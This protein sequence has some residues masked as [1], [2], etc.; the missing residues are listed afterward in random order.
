MAVAEVR[1]HRGGAWTS[2]PGAVALVL[3]VVQFFWRGHYVWGGFYYQDDFLLLRHGAESSFTLSYLMQE[4]AG[5]VW[6]GNFAMAWW[7]ARLAPTDWTLAATSILVIQAVAGAVM[8]LV[9]CRISTDWRV[10]IPLFVGYLACPLTLWAT[11]WWAAAINFVPLSLFMLLAV[12]ALLRRVQDEW[13]PGTVVVVLATFAGL[14][15]ME[16]A[17]LYPLL[18][19]GVAVLLA[20]GSFF[21]RVRGALRDLRGL[22]I[23]LVVVVGGWMAIHSSI[24][25]GAPAQSQAR[26]VAT[27]ARDYVFRSLLPGLAGGPWGGADKW[28]GGLH[29]TTAAAWV[30]SVVV[31]LILAVLVWRTGRTGRLALAL[32]LL[33]VVADFAVTA[34]G[35]AF[36]LGIPWGLFPRYVAD[37]VP[38]TVVA[39][40]FAC[41]D[42]VSRSKVGTRVLRSSR[43]TLSP[44]LVSVTVVAATVFYAA[45]SAWSTAV[46]GPLE[47]A[48]ESRDY[49]TTLRASIRANPTAVI[50]D[51]A[52]PDE[53]MTALFAEDARVSTVLATAPER[54]VFEVV[55]EELLIPGPTGHLE[56]V[57]LWVRQELR[58]DMESDLCGYRVDRV[59][60]R[61]RITVEDEEGLLRNWVVRLSYFASADTLITVRLD[62]RAQ[63]FVAREGARDAFLIVDEQTREIVLES[64]RD[65]GTVC[66]TSIDAGFPRQVLQ[67]GS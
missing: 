65:S 54:P 50:Y 38:V 9:L 15:F 56:E 52:V 44:R 11:Q 1:T 32:A 33:Y 36:A 40:A 62:G 22:W 43:V 10:R 25:S 55:S 49:V 6:P 60:P 20:E 27:A 51:R 46:I 7:T 35:R 19:G 64:P 66:V 29:P 3:L 4:Y 17:M 53:V 42:L 39:L 67:G 30:G 2:W 47:Q 16:R 37:A 18:L 57:D 26:G 24:T 12:W 14:L 41:N 8:W 21:T 58:P 5:H 28:G 48:A 45:S 34:Q 31:L 63:S 13:R 23:S 61:V 59:A